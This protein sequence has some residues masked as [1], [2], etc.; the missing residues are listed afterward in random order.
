MPP[1]DEAPS[2]GS[3]WADSWVWR[4]DLPAAS[5]LVYL[6]LTSATPGTYPVHAKVDAGDLH[7]E[8]VVDAALVVSEVPR[9]CPTPVDAV[10]YAIQEAE[11]ARD[12]LERPDATTDHQRVMTVY[13]GLL[14]ALSD[15]RDD[16]R[17]VVTKASIAALVNAKPRGAYDVR[18]RL[19]S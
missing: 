12:V 10:A 14:S 4:G 19:G 16:L 17:E 9:E 8:V 13:L 5:L 6:K 18:R 1:T 3:A 2:R 11:E 15:E 7:E